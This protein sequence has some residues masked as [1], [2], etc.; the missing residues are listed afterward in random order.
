MF[1]PSIL[2]PHS[3]FDRNIEGKKIAA[4]L[5]MMPAGRQF[6]IIRRQ[7]A[8]IEGDSMS[9]FGVLIERLAGNG[10]KDHL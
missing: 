1:L 7:T 3:G 6:V 8:L 9:T 4:H 5:L 10:R 2:L